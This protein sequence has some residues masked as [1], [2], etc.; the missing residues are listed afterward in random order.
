MEFTNIFQLKGPKPKNKGQMNF[1]ECCNLTK[2]AYLSNG[3]IFQYFFVILNHLKIL[4]TDN[5]MVSHGLIRKWAAKISWLFALVMH[6]IAE[7]TLSW[8]HF[9]KEKMSYPS[10]NQRHAYLHIKKCNNFWSL[11]LFWVFPWNQFHEIFSMKMPQI[12]QNT[13]VLFWFLKIF[14][15]GILKNLNKTET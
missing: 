8:G 6:E 1:Y 11:V 2:K 7:K 9:A 10:L 12:W 13:H 5:M 15:M 14:L 4:G 3:S